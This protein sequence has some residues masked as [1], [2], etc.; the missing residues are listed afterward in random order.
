MFKQYIFRLW[1]F[2]FFI[3]CRVR[4]SWSFWRWYCNKS[5]RETW[6][7]SPCLWV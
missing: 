7:D 4:S 5:D 1:F 3:S 2:S 6:A